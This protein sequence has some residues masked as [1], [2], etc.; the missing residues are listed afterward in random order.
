MGADQVSKNALVFAYIK[1][2]RRQHHNEERTQLQQVGPVQGQR[3][4]NVIEWKRYL[5]K[6][7]LV[8]KA[9]RLKNEGIPWINTRETDRNNFPATHNWQ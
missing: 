8:L 2:S 1:N 7:F 9:F 3:S 6:L 4:I 5:G